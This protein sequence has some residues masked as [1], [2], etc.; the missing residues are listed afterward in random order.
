MAPADSSRPSPPSGLLTRPELAEFLRVSVN[1]VDKF[2]HDRNDPVPHY[3]FGRKLLF[4]LAEVL[5]WCR[6][7]RTTR[8]TRGGRS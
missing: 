1:A 2:V 3:K 4:N 6:T 5:E 7:T 8:T